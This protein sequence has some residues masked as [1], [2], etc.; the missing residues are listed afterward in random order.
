MENEIE[1]E[2][3]E[4]EEIPLIIEGSFLNDAT[5]GVEKPGGGDEEGGEFD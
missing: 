3:P 2:R 4:L 5:L 1:Y